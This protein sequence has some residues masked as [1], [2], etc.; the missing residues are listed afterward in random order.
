MKTLLAA[1]LCY[2]AATSALAGALLGGIAWL[3]RVDATAGVATRAVPIPPRIADSIERKKAYVPPQPPQAPSAAANP[4]QQANVA[5]TQPT[6]MRPVIRE[7]WPPSPQRKTGPRT[8]KQVPA[9]ETKDATAPSYPE[10]RDRRENF[11][12]L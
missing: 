1:L 2:L 12:G 5:L 7:L 11:S 3:A 10:V 9:R 6:T 8:R 4:M